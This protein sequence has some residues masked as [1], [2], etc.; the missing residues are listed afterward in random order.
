M[1]AAAPNTI[2]RLGE[3]ERLEEIKPWMNKYLA[4]V[5]YHDPKNGGRGHVTE[6]RQKL[7]ALQQKRGL[8]IRAVFLDWAGEMIHNYLMATYGKV[9]P[10][11]L[12]LELTGLIGRCKT[13]LA[14]PFNCTVWVSHQ[15]AGRFTSLPPAR[16]PHHSEAQWCTSFADR[17]WFAFC[18]GNKDI[19]HSVCQFVAS[20]TR[21]GESGPPALLKINGAFC[22]M[23]D[24]S[25]KFKPDHAGLRLL[26]KDDVDRIATAPPPPRRNGR[27][28]NVEGDDLG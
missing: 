18:L 17:A 21:H 15:V 20:K 8:P 23:D 14:V 19:E 4:L 5:D 27:R 3:Q 1:Y 28:Q 6:V 9:E 26:P 11:S 25:D 10:G 2:E 22:R 13:E 24:V 7:A 16:R 12:A